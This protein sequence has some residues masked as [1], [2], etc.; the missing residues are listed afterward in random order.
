M[1]MLY[2]EKYRAKLYVYVIM[3][4]HAHLLIEVSNERLSKIMQ[5]IQQTFTQNYNK[6]KK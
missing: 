4:N 1:K 3:D 6:I 5:L 2:I